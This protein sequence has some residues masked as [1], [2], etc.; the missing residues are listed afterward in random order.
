MKR[1]LPPYWTTQL[2]V[3]IIVFSV[4]VALFPTG[5]ISSRFSWSYTYYW[6]PHYTYQGIFEANLTAASPITNVSVG[7]CDTIEV[8]DQR[9]EAAIPV[10]LRVYND[11]YY[12]FAVIPT[13][14]GKTPWMYPASVE[15]HFA[16]A[17]NYTVQ[18]ER[19]TEDTF[20][21]CDIHAYVHTPP[22]P[23]NPMPMLEYSYFGLGTFLILLGLGLTSDF[24]RRTKMFYWTT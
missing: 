14:G 15:L 6:E 12:L 7:Y 21:R 9:G 16:T 5:F 17:Q 24:V 19:E 20:F 4:G 11:T 23:V 1:D 10:T 13:F 2:A 22:P 3:I 8:S 18:V